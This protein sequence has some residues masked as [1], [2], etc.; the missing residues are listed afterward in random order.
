MHIRSNYSDDGYYD[1]EEIFKQAKKLGLETISIT[2]HNCARV[3]AAAPRFAKLYDIQY[4][5]G[6]EFDCQYNGERLRILGYYI[7]WNQE[8]FNVLEQESL[9]RE[10]EMSI[11]RVKKFEQ[12]SGDR[13]SV[14]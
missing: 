13:K 1:V 9:R 14:V 11:E 8:I 6:V 4:I 7:D 3:N 10:K 2:D 5:P 12:Y